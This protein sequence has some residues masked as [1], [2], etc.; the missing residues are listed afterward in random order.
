MTDRLHLS[1]KHRTV[2]LSLLREHLPGVEVWAYGSRVA[3]RSHGGSDLDL[4]LRGPGLEEIPI[5]RLEDF[6]EAVR[7]STIPFLVEARDWARLPE[8]FHHE[9]ERD[10]VVLAQANAIETTSRSGHVGSWPMV[11]LGDHVDSCLGKMLDKRKN[12]G[13]LFPYLANRN[14]RWG[15]FDTNELSQM[16]FEDHEHDRYGLKY[17]DLV[18]CE[19]GE[20]GRC[21]IWKDEIPGMK[22]QKALHRIR[23]RERMD[24]RFLCYWFLLAG[25]TG[26][27]E[28]YFTGT[29]IKHLT[30]KAIEVLQVPLPPKSEQCA[31]AGIL[32]TLDNKIE[33]N[34]RMNETLE[35]MAQAIFKDWFVDFGPTRAKA[36]GRAPYLA[37]DLW[38]LFPDALDGEGRPVGWT[39]SPLGE[40]IEILDS[41][42]IPLSS[43]ERKRRQGPYPYH[44]ATG[45]MDYVDDYLFE[46]VHVLLG[47]DGSVTKPDGKPF[48]QY[49]WGQF[50]VN[51][52]AHVLKGNGISNEML[53][54]FL[55]QADVAPY[56]TGAVQPKL[57]QKNLK[58]IP[59]SAS[60]YN[61]PA[62]FERVVEPLFQLL[63]RNSEENRTLAQTRD[64]L[65]PKL[66]S[67]EIRLQDAEK[68]VGA[69][70]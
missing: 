52:H 54:C 50:W 22:I 47:E 57:N 27:L 15:S 45:V 63:R 6:E 12:R 23:T 62:A 65:L 8:R 48:T 34:R 43:R 26:A 42:R 30:G 21:A 13:E 10:Y 41:K 70:A 40:R 64:L 68:A 7:E 36:G 1:P 3:G 44:G 28:P 69:V 19:G 61:T 55:Q 25:R 32:G 24:N 2:L 66:M 31:I 29:T 37:P 9:I 38:E 39:V 51:N 49:V 35:A 5:G 16:R 20:P 46:G 18:V 14:V 17:G 58:T 56:V 53:L 59:F 11:R 33:L 67:G 60:G 4:V